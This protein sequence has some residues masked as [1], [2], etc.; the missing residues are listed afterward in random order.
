VADFDDA[1][2]YAGYRDHPEHQAI[3]GRYSRPHAKTRAAVQ[4]EV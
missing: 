3:I 2:S 1:T 4:Y